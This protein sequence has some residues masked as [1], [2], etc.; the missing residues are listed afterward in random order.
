LA[1]S[2][3]VRKVGSRGSI[4]LI[5]VSSWVLGINGLTLA[6]NL[7]TGILIAR[8]LG[9][10]GRGELTAVVMPPQLI[11]W[12]FAMG[13]G[14]AVAFHHSRHPDDGSRLFG[15]WLV[16][17]L[18][19]ATLSLLAGELY[20]HFALAAQSP[21]TTRLA[22]IYMAMVTAV[23]FGELVYGFLLADQS[24]ILYRVLA[25]AQPS[26]TALA[27]IVL[28]RT[29]SLSVRSA[30]IAT[31]IP[32]VAGLATATYVTVSRTGIG[33]P[34][35]TLGGST[36]WYG[37]RAHGT[38]LSDLFN[39]RLDLLIIPAFLAASSVGFYA[40]ASTAS[41]LVVSLAGALAIMVLPLAARNP[42]DPSSV[43]RLTQGTVVLAFGLVVAAEV[44]A[45]FAVKVVYGGSF[46]PSVP[47]IRLL[48]PGTG[49]YAIAA[50]LRGALYAANRPLVATVSYGLGLIVTVIG[51]G[52][53]LK[54]GGLVA[55]AM[56]STVA[57][58][59]VF[60]STVIA[61]VRLTGIGLGRFVP[62]AKEMKQLITYARRHKG[63]LVV[64]GRVR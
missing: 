21:A 62:S 11:G 37:F 7:L 42:M 23:V 3:A 57:Y 22:A 8:V 44:L 64:F 26:L 61:F 40:V 10:I 49:L 63:P 28:W 1:D 59:V 48:L 58:S 25:L 15:T 50:V 34:S 47:I 38:T 29:G 60:G 51:L 6:V 32:L 19:L 53:F 52:I 30:A 35:F 14:Q 54:P 31:A 9:P 13:C 24:F 43:I 45:P 16:I 18:P 55:A 27:D 2:L 5:R 46:A 20:V 41:G 56:V 39:V 4:S 17:V 12:A 36:A 33:K